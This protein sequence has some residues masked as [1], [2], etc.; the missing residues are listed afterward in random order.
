MIYCTRSG[1]ERA[2]KAMHEA[3]MAL[4][5]HIGELRLPPYTREQWL[6]AARAETAA[7][8]AALQATYRHWRQLSDALEKWI[9][10]LDRHARA[11]HVEGGGLAFDNDEDAAA[12]RALQEEIA[13]LQ[14]ASPAAAAAPAP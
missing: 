13:T 4:E 2:I 5:R 1:G 7:R 14:D 12:A 3:R 6:A 11:F 10:F 9:L 8:D